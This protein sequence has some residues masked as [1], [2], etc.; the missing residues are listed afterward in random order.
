[1]T[2]LQ[3]AMVGGL[4]ASQISEMVIAHPLYAESLN[5]LFKKMD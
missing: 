1:M 5:N 3:M 2:V 4:T